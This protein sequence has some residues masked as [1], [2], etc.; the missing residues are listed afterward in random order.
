MS[1]SE[2]ARALRK[3][4]QFVE[5]DSLLGV[6]AVPFDRSQL[7]VKAS[8]TEVTKSAP[9]KP[10]PPRKSAPAARAS[11]NTTPKPAPAPTPSLTAVP[12]ESLDRRAKITVLTQLDEQQVRGCTK[13]KLHETRTQTVFGEG[14][15]DAQLMFIGEGPGQNEDETGRPFVGRAGELLTKMIVAM[16]LSREEIFIA[17]VIKCR[18]P[19]NR[20][21]ERDEIDA[22]RD[23]LLTQVATIAPKVIVTL[24]APATKLI[25]NTKEAIS[26]LRGNWHYFNATDPPIEVMPTFHPAYLLRSYTPEN[27]KRVWSD[28]QQVMD[29]LG[30]SEP[31][32]DVSS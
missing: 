12:I 9:A 26:R 5:S 21:P 2:E 1:P 29:R 30:I 3:L 15:P 27:R 31:S 13:C 28:L 6:D 20:D 24:G 16:G 22:C 17:N 23:Y 10:T 18:P 19:G 7:A 32:S 11:H 25:L 14:N 4:R 8:K